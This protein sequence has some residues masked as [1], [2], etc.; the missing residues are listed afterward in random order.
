MRFSKKDVRSAPAFVRRAPGDELL[1]AIF[2]GPLFTGHDGAAGRAKPGPHLPR[3]TKYWVPLVALLRGACLEELLQLRPRD[4]Y[5]KDGID[6][7]DIG[8]EGAQVK[9]FA[10][11]RLVPVHSQLRRLGFLEHAAGMRAR[12]EA[13]LFPGFAPAGPDDR[14]GHAFTRFWTEYRRGI[15][16]YLRGADLHACRHAV[17]TKLLNKLVPE[18][19]IKHVL[20][21]AQQGMTGR[22]YNSGVGLEA[23]AEAIGRLT[24]E[25]IDFAMLEAK[26]GR[27]G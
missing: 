27:P 10:R 24:Y 9:T 2:H 3:D 18:A 26:A 20:G 1:R 8:A 23:A 7:L 16:A 17:N 19:V 15:G 14:M 25:C 13:L 22:D 4:V 6:V 21:H 12:G 11:P 5:R